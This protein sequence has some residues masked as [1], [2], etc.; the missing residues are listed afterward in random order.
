MSNS[1]YH[2]ETDSLS[3]SQLKIFRK[4]PRDY[5]EQ[6]V[7]GKMPK[8]ESTLS[9]MLG[10]ICHAMLLERKSIDDIARCYPTSCLNVN[11]GLIGAKA[12]D[13]EEKIYPVLAIKDDMYEQAIQICES[14]LATQSRNGVPSIGDVLKTGAQFEQRIDAVLD[15]V[16]CRAKPD[17]HTELADVIPIHDLKFCERM[18][19]DEWWGIAK[20]LQYWLQ[21][22]HYSRIAMERYKKPVTFRFWAISV[23][24]P[25]RVQMYQY[26]DVSREIA[27]EYHSKQLAEF[28]A[29]KASGSWE[30]RW[31]S[32]GTISPWEVGANESGDIMDELDWS[33]DE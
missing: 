18:Y 31:D 19:P 33:E 9:M 7:T 10:T 12:R 13:F 6:F 23:T 25:F 17:I 14:V 3:A 26:D 30:D 15:G 22:A 27:M 24:Y 20:R 1:S 5:Y 16:A 8:R 29:C 32:T 21:D 2:S 28:A 4:S 11:G